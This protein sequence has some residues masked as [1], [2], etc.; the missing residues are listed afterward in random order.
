MQVNCF[1]LVLLAD[2][3]DFFLAY[4]HRNLVLVI[5]SNTTPFG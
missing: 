3:N 1:Y 4:Y 2:I 5:L